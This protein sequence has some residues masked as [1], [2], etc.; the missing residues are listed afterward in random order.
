MRRALT[1]NVALILA[2]TAVKAETTVGASAGR[3]MEANAATNYVKNTKAMKCEMCSIADTASVGNAKDTKEEKDIAYWAKSLLSRVKISGYAQ[4]GYYGDIVEGGGNTNSFE[5]RRIQIKATAN[6]TPQFLGVVMYNFKGSSLQE[7][8]LEYRPDKAVNLRL[9]QS[10][11]ELSIENPESNATLEGTNLSQG[12]AWLTGGDPLIGNSSGRDFGFLVYG[13]LL[14]NR[15]KYYIE[16]LNGGKINTSDQNNQKNIIAK[17]DYYLAPNFHIAVSGQKGY[18]YAVATSSINPGVVLDETY[19]EDRYTAGF[20]WFSKKEPSDYYRHRSA[21]VRA[22]VLGGRD[23]DV[24]SFG[25]YVTTAI[26]VSKGLDIVAIADYF[27]YNTSANLKRTDLTAGV[28]YWFY[29]KCRLQ[30]HYCY[31]IRNDNYQALKGGNTHGIY[32]Q[33]QIGF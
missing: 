27:N 7:Y 4:G 29:K 18:G 28:Q 2:A 33:F 5:T 9:G 25:G 1:L 17:L 3:T 13:S 16:A 31:S 10:K 26:P 21:T 15:L 11:T 6:I 20:E 23:K 24:H 8:Y 19:R 32:S 12:V 30:L 22:E 14:K